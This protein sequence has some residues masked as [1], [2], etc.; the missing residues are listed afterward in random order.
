MNCAGLIREVFIPVNQWPELCPV[1]GE[2]IEYLRNQV[3]SMRTPGDRCAT[4][5]QV[6]LCAP[7]VHDAGFLGRWHSIG[8]AV[9]LYDLARLWI[10]FNGHRSVS[11]DGD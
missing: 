1:R 4:R 6:E 8:E 3:L 5:L 11:L 2:G 9:D 10:H 7:T